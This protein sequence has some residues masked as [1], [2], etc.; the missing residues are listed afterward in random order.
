MMWLPHWALTCPSSVFFKGGRGLKGLIEH[1]HGG[2][3]FQHALQGASCTWQCTWRPPLSVAHTDNSSMSFSTES[4][5]SRAPVFKPS[6]GPTRLSRNVGSSVT[7]NCTA[8]LY[9]EPQEEQC[10]TTLQWSKDGQL[11][12]NHTLYTENA[13]SWWFVAFNK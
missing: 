1:L 11:L 9:W 6:G 13:S 8:L 5:C 2:I 7:L 10:D 3:L 12:N 4:Q